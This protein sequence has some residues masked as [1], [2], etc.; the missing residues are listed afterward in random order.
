MDT[1]I[2]Y[3]YSYN[4]RAYLTDPNKLLLSCFRNTDKKNTIYDNDHHGCNIV[5]LYIVAK[6][7][8]SFIRTMFIVLFLKDY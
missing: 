3:I 7:D 4:I 6:S 2:Q 1:F 8:G 5:I